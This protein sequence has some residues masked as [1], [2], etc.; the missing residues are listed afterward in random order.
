MC[1]DFRRSNADAGRFNNGGEY[2]R[3]PV[4]LSIGR[5]RVFVGNV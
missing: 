2:F 3:K 5:R 4:N 1:G